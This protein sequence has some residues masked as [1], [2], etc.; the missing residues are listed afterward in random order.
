MESL[1]I[2]SQF[3]FY[4]A[5]TNPSVNFEEF[6]WQFMTS[7]NSML[8]VK[9]WNRVLFYHNQCIGLPWHQSSC[10]SSPNYRVIYRHTLKWLIK[11]FILSHISHPTTQTG[12][13]L[14]RFSNKRCK[15]DES[16][17][18]GRAVGGFS[19]SYYS[20]ES[21]IIKLLSYLLSLFSEFIH[22]IVYLHHYLKILDRPNDEFSSPAELRDRLQAD[23]RSGQETTKSAVWFFTVAITR[24]IFP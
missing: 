7:R 9:E 4:A 16:A 6:R 11:L 21:V 8:E 23:V 2:C 12:V 17:K 3:L 20:A 13:I 19:A 24:N 15:H 14:L 22:T 5:S 18:G 10:D 1:V